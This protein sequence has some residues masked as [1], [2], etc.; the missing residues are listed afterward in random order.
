MTEDDFPMS[1]EPPDDP[2]SDGEYPDG[3]SGD[4]LDDDLDHAGL[5][6]PCPHCGREIY[7][8]AVRCPYCANYVIWRHSAWSA[9]SWWWIALG[10]L[11]VVAAVLALVGLTA[12]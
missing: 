3:D 9:R 12:R 8:E 6:A 11:G 2:L 10:L 7:E 5:T 1:F 4:E